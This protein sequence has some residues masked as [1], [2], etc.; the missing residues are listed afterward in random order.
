MSHPVVAIRNLNYYFGQGN[1]RSQILFDINLEI[2]PGEFV[3]MTGPSGSGKS[4]LLSLIGCLREV[5][6]GSLK[7]LGQ[8]LK[9]A[10]PRQQ[11]QVRYHFGYIFQ[12]SNLLKF[13][14]AEQNTHVSLELNSDLNH[15]EI[16]KRTHN[17]LDT[18]GL[19]PQAHHY[20][21]QLSGGQKQRVSIACALVNR[22]ALVLADEP[23]AALDSRSGRRIVELM[24][25]LAKERGSA[26]LM[27]THDQRILD[28]AD[29]IIQV[30]D[31]CLGL[32][33]RQELTLALPGLKEEQLETIAIK[34]T[35]VTYE[36]EA[37]IFHEGD[38]SD[39]FYVVI[40]GEVQAVQENA[41][42]LLRVLN[43]IGRGGYFG[44]IGVL[45]GVA[46]TASVRVSSSSAAK[47]MVIERETF[48][49]LIGESHLTSTAIAQEMQKRVNVTLLSEALPA[50]D[51]Q[52]ILRILP[53][54]DIIKYG[55]GSNIMSQGDAAENFYIIMSG[56]VEILRRD[57]KGEEILINTL[58]AGNY[59]GE[60]GL[61]EGRSRTA[62]V[63]VAPDNS[64]E[65]IVL[66]GETFR[67]LIETC[68]ASQVELAKV[69]YERLKNVVR[70]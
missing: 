12:S 44:E 10:T 56:R 58:S 65:V 18:V 33:Y 66:D 67:Q 34:P 24:H 51:L 14:T 6:E 20:P 15:S 40:Q 25:R 43:T 60:I 63:R 50:A 8:E 28:I 36:S 9:G 4:T 54:V 64:V 46:R 32:G 35:I 62:T 29:R 45:Q 61:M 59:F 7:I 69:V 52:Q 11:T 49:A 1:L 70:G 2:Q 17:I 47:L 48:L 3:I 38:T 19:L 26:V 57:A 23:T 22:P 30:E 31:G 55:P 13:L 27:V 21:R 37:F 39:K 42:Q 41:G 68:S 53:Q 5:Q 16:Q